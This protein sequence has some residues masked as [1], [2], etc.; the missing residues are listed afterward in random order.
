M[1]GVVASFTGE[2]IASFTKGDGTVY[3]DS[4]ETST[5][6]WALDDPI[7]EEDLIG[8]LEDGEPECEICGLL[9]DPVGELLDDDQVG[10]CGLKEF[11]GLKEILS[12]LLT[13]RVPC[14]EGPE[15]GGFEDGLDGSGD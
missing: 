12:K 7:L 9:E 1:G 10:C 11:D 6:I 5:E 3:K 14:E 4:E 13:A 8:L 2:T 15:D